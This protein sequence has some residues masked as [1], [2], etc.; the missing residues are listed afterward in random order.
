MKDD[1]TL[2][3]LV[4]E[5]Q[6]DKEGIYHKSSLVNGKASWTSATNAIWYYGGD[7]KVWAIGSLDKIGT[8]TFGIHSFFDIT[9]QCPFDLPGEGWKY[10]ND[11]GFRHA[12]TNEISV[13]CKGKVF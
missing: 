10:S 4:K 5:V 6:G 12:Y 2:T 1:P 7:L 9:F 3:A 13:V 11:G 8:N